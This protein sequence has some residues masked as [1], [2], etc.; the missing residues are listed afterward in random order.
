MQCLTAPQHAQHAQGFT[1]A[2]RT[3]NL[4]CKTPCEMFK[5]AAEDMLDLVDQYPKLL[6]MLNKVN[7]MRNHQ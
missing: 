3:R 7:R 2:K 4:W 5:I 6:D 1:K